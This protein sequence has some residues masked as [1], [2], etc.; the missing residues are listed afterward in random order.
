MYNHYFSN[1]NNTPAVF[2]FTHSGTILKLLSHLGLYKDDFVLSHDTSEDLKSSRK[3]KTSQIDSFGAN[4][5]FV[6]FE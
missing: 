6:N 2:Y 1:N 4:L 3:W 5:V